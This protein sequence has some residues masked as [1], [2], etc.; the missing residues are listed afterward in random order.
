MT[1]NEKMDLRS[2]DIVEEKREKLKELFPEVFTEGQKIDLERL[3]LTL[4]EAVD[5]GKERYGMNWPGK[6]DC[7]KIIQQPSIATLTPAREESVNFD[8]TENL[9]IEGDNL[10]VLKLLQK[11]YLGKIKM[12]E[13]DPPYNTGNDFIY[14]DNY[15]ESLDTY[16]RYTGQIDD[17]GRKYSTNTEADGRF[18]SKWM[19]MMYPRLF[20]ARNLLR[21]DG[22]IF[23]HI[24]DTEVDNLRKICDEIFGEG[25]F[26]NF[27][28]WKKRYN[29][30]KEHHLANNHDFI[31]IYARNKE[32]IV[33]FTTPGDEEYYNELFSE[34]DEH[35][36]TRGKFMTQPL[37]AGNS[38]GDRSNLRFPVIA[39][40]GTEIW[41]R[42]QWVWGQERVEEA[43]K[44]GYL[45][46]Y[47]DRNG[48]WKIRHKHYVKNNDGNLRRVK[49]FSIYDKC[50]TQ[51]GTKEIEELFPNND[52]FPFPKP[53]KLIKHFLELINDKECLVLD[54]FSGSSTT[55]HAVLDLN[56][57]GDSRKFI[58]VQLPEPCAPESEAYKAGY[59][60][61]ADI[62]KERIRRVIKKI[63]DEQEQK[64]D[65][66]SGDKH[67]LDL[68][69]KVFKLEP[70]NFKLWN[71]QVA[72]EKD[73]I[74]NQLEMFVEHI[75]PKSSQE[76]ILY[77]LLLKSGFPLT[78]K[79]EQLTMTDKVVFSIDEGAM[80][81]CL[82]KDLTPEV[83]KAMAEKK[84]VRVICLDEGLHG[85]DQLKTNA[86]QIMK[87]RDIKFRTV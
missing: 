85:N 48:E 15:S 32:L 36:A 79:I 28:I 25:N 63:K 77:E 51:D 16:L 52:I 55:A 23:I 87:S 65:L 78:T 69:F 44:N 12:I 39:P 49:P 67:K 60:T 76:D 86:V 19:N 42:R 10:E 64:K 81:I 14:P 75:N 84:P 24:D 62:G 56:R 72:K 57:A 9:F 17:E 21:E 83:I 11:S 43:K 27:L 18:H 34:T 3:R 20:L 6:A 54:F 59:K 8:N 41:P 73:A 7:F 71:D 61:I 26:I 22:V 30:A 4:G 40:D 80:L 46:F 38:M 45:K 33:D 82:E 31:L 47:K 66:F 68:G 58:M 35:E 1:D 13:I 5:V 74:K 2:M 70:S 53:S 37:E 29:A 50:F